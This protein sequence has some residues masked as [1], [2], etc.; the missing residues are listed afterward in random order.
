[1]N[2]G[3]L[4]VINEFVISTRLLKVKAYHTGMRLLSITSLGIYKSLLLV[5]LQIRAIRKISL[6]ICI[7][8]LLSAAC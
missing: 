3:L 1:M 7:E 5:D 6:C 2:I 4:I 8:L